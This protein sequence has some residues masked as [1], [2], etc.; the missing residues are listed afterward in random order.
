MKSHDFLNVGIQPRFKTLFGPTM[1]KTLFEPKIWGQNH[2]WAWPL[3]HQLVTWI[4]GVWKGSSLIPYVCNTLFP[5]ITFLAVAQSPGSCKLHLHLW[6]VTSP[7]YWK[8]ARGPGL[9][10]WPPQRFNYFPS[11]QLIHNLCTWALFLSEFIVEKQGH[12]HAFADFF[13]FSNNETK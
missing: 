8:R 12:D 11:E 5:G 1:W 13:T 10:W 2:C 6:S 3:G 7:S 9:S 4:W